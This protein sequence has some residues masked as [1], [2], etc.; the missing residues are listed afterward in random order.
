MISVPCRLHT[1][2]LTLVNEKIE[3]LA[4]AQLDREKLIDQTA[5]AKRR[6]Q[7][8]AQLH[9]VVADMTDKMIA[10]LNSNAFIRVVLSPMVL[11]I[12]RSMLCRTGYG[13]GL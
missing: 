1:K 2:V 3:E 8:V 6:M 11:R 13:F 9:D 12:V 4:D 10:R 5:R 7:L